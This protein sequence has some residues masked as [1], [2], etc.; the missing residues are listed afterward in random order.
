MPVNE[1]DI[2]NAIVVRHN[3]N[4]V[5]MTTVNAQAVN[6]KLQNKLTAYTPAIRK[7]IYT[8][9]CGTFSYESC[10]RQIERMFTEYVNIQTNTRRMTRRK[11][12]VI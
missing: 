8:L 6:N 5:Y 1:S 12:F 10:Y 2:F 4:A 11:A 3:T 7:N 9:L